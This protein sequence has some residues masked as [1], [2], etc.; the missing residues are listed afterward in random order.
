[1][2]GKG[3]DPLR[4]DN[5]LCF[6]L[7]A[8]AREVVKRYKPFL[9]AIG[10]TYTQYVTMMV[11]WECPRITSKE[12]GARLHLDSGTLTPVIKRLAEK[13]LV[14]RARDMADE[15]NLVVGLTESGRALRDRAAEIPGRI[16]ACI[17]LA[18]GEMEQLYEL[19]YRLLN[20]LE[21]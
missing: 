7:Y 1:M 14:T 5:Q 19:L 15:R 20:G 2:D 12:I 21:G 13:G 11:L 17:P 8:C 18:A 16:G 6:P 4:L 9:D 10:L 3:P